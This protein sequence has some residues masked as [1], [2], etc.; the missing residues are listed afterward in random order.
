VRSLLTGPASILAGRRSWRGAL[1]AL[2][3]GLAVAVTRTV[4]QAI[5]WSGESW[6]SW[7]L[8]AVLCPPV[9]AT[10]SRRAESAADRF[11]AALG[12]IGAKAVP[13]LATGAGHDAAILGAAPGARRIPTGMLFVRN[14]TGVSHSPDEFAEPEDCARGG[15]A[16]T[17]VLR[18][19]LS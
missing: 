6:R 1:I 11:A 15:A 17:S 3:V 7:G 2:V 12:D 9:D 5:G 13:V 8:A 14:P 16:L 4:H 10:I 18:E 19:L